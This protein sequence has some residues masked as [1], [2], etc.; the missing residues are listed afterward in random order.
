[1][2]KIMDRFFRIPVYHPKATL[3]FLAAVTVI[4]C[5]GMTKIRFENSLE[6]MMPK[7]DIEYITNEKLKE[8]YGNNGKFI[9]LDVS[10]E[11][12]F[13]RE[14]FSEIEL[15]TREIEEYRDYDEERESSR[16]ARIES[17]MESNKVTT[18]DP[19]IASLSDDPVFARI[20]KRKLGKNILPQ[21]KIT[22]GMLKNI[23]AS[24][25][26][27][28]EIKKKAPV[29]AILSPLTMKDLSGKDDTLTAYD[30]LDKDEN[31]HRI[32]PSTENEFSKFREKLRRNPAFKNG[33]YVEDSRGYITDFGILIR[34]AES[35]E[36]NETAHELREIAGSYNGSAGMK[37]IAQG[38]PVLYRQIID[39]MQRDL[40][41]FVPLVLLVICLIFYLNFRTIQGVILPLAT[42]LMADAWTLGLMG[43]LGVRISVIGISLPP[44]I[45]SVGSSYSI[46]IMNRFLIDYDNIKKK[47]A[48]GIFTS[49][50]MV[51]MTLLLA[52]ITTIIGFSTNMATQ[53]SSIFD[54]GLF[55]ALGTFFAVAIAALFIPSVYRFIELKKPSAVTIRKKKSS[56]TGGLVDH[57]LNFCSVSSVKHPGYVLSVALVLVSVSVAGIF[58]IKSET[59]LQSYFSKSDYINT[60]N[61][62]IGRKFGGTMGINI[63]IDS[64]EMD[65][66][67]DPVFLNRVEELRKW[68]TSPENSDLHIGRTDGFGDFVHTINMA[69]HNDDPSCYS[70]PD[71]KTDLLDYFEIYSGDDE[72]S[73]GRVDEF[74]P[75]VDP[76][77]R[78]VNIFAR[79]SESENAM[80][81]T[82]EISRIVGKIRG[83]FNSELS[84]YGY[85]VTVSGDPLIIISLAKY[86]VRGQLWSLFL[87]LIAVT[88]IV[89]ILFK[90]RIAGLISSVPIS[91][92]VIVNFGIMGWFGIRL[93]IAT[94]IIASITIGIGVD[95]TI[96]FLN[97]YRYSMT[98]TSSMDEAIK[99]TLETGGK[100]IIFTALALIAGFSILVTSQFKPIVFFGIMM[101]FTFISTTT[102]AL[103]ILP[104]LIKITG[105]S[106]DERESALYKKIRTPFNYISNTINELKEIGFNNLLHER[107]SKLNNSKNMN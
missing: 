94:A 44:L 38:A 10:S 19:L 101:G 62:E 53:V 16:I 43:Y 105:F 93:D 28:L 104:A 45:I 90:N 81:G 84:P 7:H 68:L 14:S 33:I 52:S 96:H 20:V 30:F 18:V 91:A 29:D 83:H 6:V 42:L 35:E 87:S 4:A 24:L 27:S 55:S 102:G 103:L 63:L 32:L 100:A 67:K 48:D 17:L 88:I 11:N 82:S 107:I 85:R 26:K 34:L 9:I 2:K 58:Q 56:G 73:D 70:I 22:A 71:S 89:M 69:M 95:N 50:Q 79:L 12:L 13:N 8:I 80:L 31:G 64:G 74:E 106:L 21:E 66:I 49:M 65:G 86:I 72:N 76:E 46:H 36:H 98:K 39:Y 57:I 78:T 25:K 23:C 54:W 1:M 51:G 3:I 92:A 59:S 97:T 47:G 77:F 99:T 41:F 15:L 60:S 61:C 5:I 37:I 75:Y 40:K